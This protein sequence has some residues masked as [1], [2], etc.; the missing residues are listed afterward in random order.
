MKLKVLGRVALAL[1]LLYGVATAGLYVAMKRPPEAFG[2]VMA[3]MP[4]VSMI[5]LP[6]E[7]LWMSA[8]AGVLHVGDAAPDFSLPTLDHGRTVHLSD[9]YRDR[10][11]V[12][13]FGS[14][15]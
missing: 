10:P 5:V 2:A 12:L 3:R 4:M 1:V 15:T 8:R 14:Y 13:I 11:V 9:E 7:P 6:F